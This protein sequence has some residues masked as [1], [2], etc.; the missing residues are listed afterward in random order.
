MDSQ[1][2]D[3]DS[4]DGGSSVASLSDDEADF[5]SERVSGESIP[6]T[7]IMDFLQKTYRKRRVK[8]NDFFAGTHAFIIGAQ[9]VAQ[10]SATLQVSDNSLKRLKRYL[11]IARKELNP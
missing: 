2:N 11:V 1:C 8:I 3:C 6:P 7:E 5:P 9:V 4:S 10:Q